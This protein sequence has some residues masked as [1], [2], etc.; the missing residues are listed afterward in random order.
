[1]DSTR[2]NEMSKVKINGQL[3]RDDMRKLGSLDSIFADN[4]GFSRANFYKVTSENAATT[5]SLRAMAKF[6]G[7]DYR[8]YL[9]KSDGDCAEL[10]EIP[11]HELKGEWTNIILEKEYYEPPTWKQERIIIDQTGTRVSGVFVS[12]KA[13]LPEDTS[14]DARY[15]MEG[16]IF[17]DCV[18]GTYFVDGRAG[19]M[20][21]GC[22]QLRIKSQG[23]C[24]GACTFWGTDGNICCSHNILLSRNLDDYSSQ[25]NIAR[26]QL[27]EAATYFEIN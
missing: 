24:E 12:E 1:M 23:Y 26:R 19:A 11:V 21:T 20:G 5:D 16:R 17:G 9:E 7:N 4:P 10:L 25:L 6:A 3:L 27:S 18:L 2:D 15:Q 22:F 14:P 13:D 8:R